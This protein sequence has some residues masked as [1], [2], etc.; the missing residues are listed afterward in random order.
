MTSVRILYQRKTGLTKSSDE[1]TTLTDP[2]T[3]ALRKTLRRPS[4]PLTPTML[5]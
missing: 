4:T 3:I 2:E 5:D 1:I